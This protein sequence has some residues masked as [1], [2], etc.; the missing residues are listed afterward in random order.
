MK[1]IAILIMS[2]AMTATATAQS[3][4][5][6]TR[7]INPEALVKIYKALGVEAKGRV[8][9]KISTGEGG[10]KHYLKP[11]LIGQ[12]VDEVNGTIVECCTAYGGT[13][14]DPKEHWK[15]IEEHGFSQRFAV[16]L[17][18]EFGEI[19]IPV[20]DRKHLRYDIVGE[21]LANYDF[22][23]NL[24]HFKGHAMGGFGGVLKNASIGVAST[25]GKAYIHSVGITTDPVECWN[26]TENQDGFL[27]SMA[28]AAQAVHN[29]FGEGRILY[30]DVMNN[31]SV[32]CDCDGTPE[33]PRMK[34]VGI[35]ASTDPVALDKACT[36]LVFNH[37]ASEDDDQQP[38]IERINRQHGLHILDYAASIGLGSLKYELVN[39]DK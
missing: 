26:H 39:L 38:L 23:I 21:H 10:N 14:Q 28:A 20:K 2:L 35:L 13:R 33:A 18:D 34:D 19:R 1:K 37:K 25:S 11:E 8:A 29:Y 4:V 5:Y 16:D 22:M 31:L 32:D 12:L 6:F 30:I 9:V 36:D 27:E 17:M 3:R 7:D 15:T 24:A